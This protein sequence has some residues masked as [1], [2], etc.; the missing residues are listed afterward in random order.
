MSFC[1]SRYQGGW[2]SSGGVCGR[3]GTTTGPFKTPSEEGS[4]LTAPQLLHLQVLTLR[5]LPPQAAH[6]GDTGQLGHGC[7]QPWNASC[8]VQS[9][10]FLSPF[11][12]HTWTLSPPAPAPFLP[13]HALVSASWLK[14][15]KL[16]W[17][18]FKDFVGF[19]DWFKIGAV[20]SPADRKE[21][22]G[23]YTK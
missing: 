20:S 8:S 19:T 2:P 14:K 21:L 1:D 5:L 18:H 12:G 3:E 23:S 17:V 4:W 15:S 13:L 16:N 7:H 22:G 11:T 6:S 10:S 9:S